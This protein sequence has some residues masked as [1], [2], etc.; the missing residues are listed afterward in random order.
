MYEELS[1]K[2]SKTENRVS[3]N[4]VQE[5]TVEYKTHEEE[6]LKETEWIRAK[7]RDRKKRKMDTSLTSSQHRQTVPVPVEKKKSKLPHQ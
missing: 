3:T 6:L 2:F 5:T 7:T 1:K 4:I